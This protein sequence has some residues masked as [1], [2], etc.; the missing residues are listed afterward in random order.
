MTS[1]PKLPQAVK[2]HSNEISSDFTLC[3]AAAWICLDY[4]NQLL[5]RLKKVSVWN[6]L[7]IV[8][9]YWE[10]KVLQMVYMHINFCPLRQRTRNLCFLLENVSL[11]CYRIFSSAVEKFAYEVIKLQFSHFSF[12]GCKPG[13]FCFQNDCLYHLW[14][15]RDNSQIDTFRLRR[16]R[17]KLRL[18][19]VNTTWILGTRERRLPTLGPT[20]HFVSGAQ[21]G[22]FD[23]RDVF[24][25]LSNPLAFFRIG[26]N[27]MWRH[28]V[29]PDALCVTGLSITPRP[30]KW[31]QYAC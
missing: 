30:L 16:H 24:S 25:G 31:P 10:T 11:Q 2:Q 18:W 5:L 8:N 23:W 12:A 21:R 7:L 15:K 28:H 6:R 4:K 1:G 17:A 22:F 26:V 3:Y 13:K 9:V 20:A 27:C 29:M 14:N 19:K